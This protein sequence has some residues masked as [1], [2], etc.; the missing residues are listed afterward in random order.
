MSGAAFRGLAALV[1]LLPLHPGG[2]GAQ[3]AQQATRPVP[4]ERSRDCDLQFRPVYSKGVPTST[5]TALPASPGRSNYFVGGGVDAVCANTDQRVRSDSAE[6]FGDLRILV[7]IGR[8]HYSE[9]RVDLH[10]DRMTYFMA[11]E[12]LHAEGRV[13]GRTSTG[14]TFSGPDA[15][16]LR[17]KPG[18][19]ATSRLDA[20][21]RPDTWISSLDLGSDTARTDS[22]HVVADSLISMNDSLI[23]AIGAVDLTRIDLT[24]RADSA[25]MDQGRETIA[26]RKGP[27]VEGTGDRRFTL[28]GDAIDVYSRDRSVERVRSSGRADAVSDGVRLTADSIDLRL[29]DRQLSRAIAWG[30]GRAHAVQPGRD[31]VAD[32]IDVAMPGQVIQSMH[33]VG[34]ARVESA[35]DSARIRTKERDW[36]SGDTIRATFD[37]PTPA[38]SG[39]AAIRQLTAIGN[40]RSWQFSARDGVA[41]PDSMPAINYVSGSS[42]VA[43][44]DSTRALDRVRVTGQAAGVVVQPAADT[45]KRAATVR[46][47]P[48]GPR[49]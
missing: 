25:M 34:R 33:A 37:A 21:G 9:E 48:T 32:S 24:A 43:E 10:A 44:F 38:D 40:A 30:K 28:T 13:K 29:S 49:R 4:Q 16:Y 31:I 39:R 8:V 18:L 23:Y 12:R 22:T 6:Q 42:V 14:T 15:M 2:A 7:L 3:Q 35:P 5:I 11:E 19:R 45:A 17:A 41:L 27:R 36:F 26:L 46:K 47:P 1:V 20:G